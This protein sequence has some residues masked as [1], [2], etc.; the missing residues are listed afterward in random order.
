MVKLSPIATDVQVKADQARGAISV[1][2]TKQLVTECQDRF[3][4]IQQQV[5]V[6]TFQLPWKKYLFFVNF[7]EKFVKYLFFVNI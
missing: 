1:T 4:H 3:E 6:S 2:P 7:T 5:R